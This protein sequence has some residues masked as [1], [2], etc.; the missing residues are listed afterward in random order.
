MLDVADPLP[1][2]ELETLQF[3]LTQDSGPLSL[4]QADQGLTHLPVSTRKQSPVPVGQRQELAEEPRRL[5]PPADPQE[6]NDLNE[7]PGV[8]LAGAFHRFYQLLQAGQESVVTD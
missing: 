3:P 6:I 8:P 1:V 7:E 4:R 2:P 5:R